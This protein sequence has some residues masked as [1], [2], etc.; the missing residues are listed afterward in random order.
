MPY[1][2]QDGNCQPGEQEPVQDGPHCE[3]KA[4]CH[5]CIKQKLSGRIAPVV[6]RRPLDCKVRG[7]NP[8][9]DTMALL[10]ERHYEFPQ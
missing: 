8:S 7:S 1:R 6:E 3:Q 4:L 10:L 5:T 9:H 2:S